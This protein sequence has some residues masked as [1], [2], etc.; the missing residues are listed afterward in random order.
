M[1]SVNL[2]QASNKYLI[3]N[4]TKDEPIQLQV[5]NSSVQVKNGDKKLLAT[6][7]G[8]GAIAAA[9]IGIAIAIKKGKNP[10]KSLADINF[11]KGI[12]KLNNGK[13]YTGVIQDTLKNGDKITLEYADGILKKSA[14]TGSISF[15]KVYETLEDGS[16]IVTKTQGNNVV[17]T[18]IT[19]IQ[20]SVK[21]AQKDLN[22]LFDK[23]DELDIS[24]FK[25]QAD[26]IVYKSRKQQSEIDGILA[27]KQK[28]IDTK[29]AQEEAVKDTKELAQ[30]A[31]ESL[32]QISINQSALTDLYT[33]KLKSNNLQELVDVRNKLSGQ[34]VYSS[35]GDTTLS[36][37]EQR[38]NAAIREIILQFD[39]KIETI[40][41]QEKYNS[42]AEKIQLISDSSIKDTATSVSVPVKIK[43]GV[44][45]NGG[46]YLISIGDDTNIYGLADVCCP[47]DSA[48]LPGI[49]N[50]YNESALELHYLA[51]SNKTN[52]A[53][54][55][56]IKQIVRDSQDLGY[57]GRVKVN[58]SGGSLP[59][60]F[61]TIAGQDKMKT[62]PVPFYYKCGFRFE[63]QEMNKQVEEGIANLSK[64]L[65]YTG[66]LA[67]NMFLPDYEIQKLL[68][69]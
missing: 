37:E 6:L 24:D 45:E 44:S 20:N 32:S 51:G 23:K 43:K 28:I 68:N 34:I 47:K 12:A 39:E 64:G 14:R 49:P 4:E 63:N 22:K 19:D 7:V 26:A 53:G 31:A 21:K 2:S 3:T 30:E 50:G 65:S 13:N 52:G 33:D 57:D 10:I 8:L 18:N 67:G 15:E 16:R 35:Y 61:R 41:R 17:K 36:L 29:K 59:Y 62:S 55:E 11:N 27:Q 56:L 69:S 58:A 1:D 46:S 9:G 54:K 66:P 5:Q 48:F 60:K 38:N 40:K 25:K 42:I